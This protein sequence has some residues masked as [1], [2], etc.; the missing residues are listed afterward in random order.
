M[1]V[2]K[3]LLFALSNGS[4]AFVTSTVPRSLR[5]SLRNRRSNGARVIWSVARERSQSREEKMEKALS[6][7]CL[8]SR[9]RLTRV[10]AKRQLSRLLDL[11]CHCF[12]LLPLPSFSRR[13]SRMLSTLNIG[14]VGK[15]LNLGLGRFV[16]LPCLNS[17]F[18]LAINYLII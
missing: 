14:L 16:C 2:F 10:L 11:Y 15:D 6:R 4:R 9:A 13:S 17:S 8:F 7:A 12:S 5:P 18:I 3:I 1:L